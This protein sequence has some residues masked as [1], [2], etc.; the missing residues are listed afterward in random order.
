MFAAADPKAP[1]HSLPARRRKSGKSWITALALVALAGCGGGG[2][3]TQD[4]PPLAG[5]GDGGNGGGNGGGHDSGKGRAQALAVSAPGDLA[6]WAQDKLRTRN[7]QGGGFLPAGIALGFLGNGVAPT[8]SADGTARS[9]TLV[10]ETGV[11][12]ADLL[13]G[14]G[15]RLFTLQPDDGSAGSRLALQIYTRDANGVAQ[16]GTRLSLSPSL[17]PNPSLINPRGA[18][19]SSNGMYLNGDNTA[20]LVVTQNWL[21]GDEFFCPGSCGQ[22]PGPDAGTG[23]NAPSGPNGTSIS[24]PGWLHGTVGV[25]RVDVP[26]GGTAMLTQRIDIE[27]QFVDSRRIGDTLYVVSSFDPHPPVYALAANASAAEREAAINKTTASDLL[28]QVRVNGGAAQP[29]LSDTDC[30]LQPANA[31]QDLRVTTITAI[32]LRSPT[33]ARSSRCMVGGTEALYMSTHSL[34]L[35][36]TRFS[37]TGI[38]QGGINVGLT[39]ARYPQRIE[40]DIHKFALASTGGI[41]YRGSGTVNGHLGWDAQRKSLRLSEHTGDLRVLSF[42]GETGWFGFADLSDNTKAP[43]PATLSILRERSSDQTLQLIATLPNA[44]RPAAIGKP[45]E[46]VYGVRFVGDRGYVVTFRR[47]D[48]LYVLDLSNPADPKTAGE[49]EIAGFSEHLFPL[50]GGLL[51][52]IGRNADLQGRITGLKL[53]LFDVANAN[54]PRALAE[55]SL[56]GP[57]SEMTLDYSRHGLN[58]LVKGNVVRLAMPVS[59]TANSRGSAGVAGLQ[60]F[61]VD[62]QSRTLTPLAIQAPQDPRV[63]GGFRQ[64]WLDRSLQIGEQ[65]Y[66]LDQGQLKTFNW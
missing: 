34:Y 24:L 63:G 61:E 22:L 11:D 57:G 40:T 2:G 37:Y 14:A 3:A 16:P 46:Q 42:T 43:S 44:N 32:D 50:D 48:P 31:A 12:E 56:G 15:Q 36:T 19:S 66:F 60:R 54:A 59:L 62:L 6:K 8:A 5:G 65:V 7:V 28:P 4:N 64:L 55:Q 20:L 38:G 45:G 1:P 39:I 52:G 27:G 53:A 58:Y 49:L 47:T 51:L 13:L 23:P 35:A 9:S 29:L 30:Y 26:E 41:S 25:Q 21:N 17:S 18:I 33:L 10:Q